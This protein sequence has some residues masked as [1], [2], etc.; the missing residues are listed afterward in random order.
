MTSWRRHPGKELS[1]GKFSFCYHGCWHGLFYSLYPALASG[2]GAVS[3]ACE[4]GGP[5]RTV[6]TDT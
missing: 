6:D 1:Q 5:A 3:R 2:F 4:T